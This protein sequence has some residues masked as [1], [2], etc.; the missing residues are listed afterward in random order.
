MDN[1]T[2]KA[3]LEQLHPESY[4]WALSCCRRNPRDAESVL[5]TVYLK[6]LEG[7][8]RFEGRSVFKTWLFSVI[9]RTAANRRR[10][11]LFFNFRHVKPEDAEAYSARGVSPDERLYQSEVHKLFRQ[12]FVGL[13]RRQREVLQLVFYHGLNLGEA[14]QVMGVSLGSSRTHYERG[15]KRLRQILL[16]AKVIHDSRVGR[17]DIPGTV[18]GTETGR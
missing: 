11:L 17:R 7:R 2:L 10:R 6:I 4:G 1:L 15:K 14:A 13:P 8:A 3:Q 18:P 5:Q 12:A 16:K 9:R